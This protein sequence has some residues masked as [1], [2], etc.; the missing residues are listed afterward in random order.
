[1]IIFTS[2]KK[3]P[4]ISMHVINFEIVPFCDKLD[5]FGDMLPGY[6]LLQ[7]DWV[8]PIKTEPLQTQDVEMHDCNKGEVEENNEMIIFCP[9]CSLLLTESNYNLHLTSLNHRH[10]GNKG[11]K[12]HSDKCYREDI[13]SLCY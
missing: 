11:L 10:T 3:E 9:H 7:D 13:D 2:I 6:D 5:R 1:M 12:Y 4:Q 8:V